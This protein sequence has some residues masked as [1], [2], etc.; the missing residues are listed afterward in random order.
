[1]IS[2]SCGCVKY[3][4]Q[5]VTISCFLESKMHHNKAIQHTLSIRILARSSPLF[6]SFSND[7]FM[8]FPLCLM[9]YPQVF[10][11]CSL[12]SPTSSRLFHR[13]QPLFQAPSACTCH[14][15]VA[16]ALSELKSQRATYREQVAFP[17]C[18]RRSTGDIMETKSGFSWGD[19]GHEMIW[20]YHRKS[21]LEYT[22]YMVSWIL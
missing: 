20:I 13:P 4:N 3:S 15:G 19:R 17:A 2:H 8:M 5:R 9:L 16:A 7:F 14:T 21:I 12:S 18:L 6:P 22:G 11:G 10:Q 1:M